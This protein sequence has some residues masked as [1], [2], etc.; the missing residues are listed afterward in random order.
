MLEEKKTDLPEQHKEEQSLISRRKLLASLGMAGVA[1]ASSGIVNAALTTK[2]YADPGDNRTKVKDLMQKALVVSAT[3]AELRTLNGPD[4]NALYFVTDPEQ[5][6]MFSY[7]PSDTASADNGG[8]ILVSSAGARYFR[9]FDGHVNVKWFGAKGNNSHDDT[10]AIQKAIDAKQGTVFLPKGTYLTS[11]P[12]VIGTGDSLVGEG[13]EITIIE[14]TTTTAA[15]LGTRKAG[16]S[17]D[18]YNVDAVII[19]LAP[20]NDYARY[21]H[22]EGLHVRRGTTHSSLP[23]NDSFCFY[24]PRI[25]FL[26]QKNVEYRYAGTGYYTANAWMV[27]LERV[28]SRWVNRGFVC[29]DR[30]AP[31]GGGTGHT[32]TSCWA[33]SCYIGAWKIHAAYSSLIACGA[34]G[35]GSVWAGGSPT[36]AAEY[37]YEINAHG[38]NILSCGTEVARGP[39]FVVKNRSTVNIFGLKTWAYYGNEPASGIYAFNIQDQSEVTVSGGTLTL[40]GAGQIKNKIAKVAGGSK[41]TIVGLNTVPSYLTDSSQ[42]VVDSSSEV[43]ISGSE[44]RS[45]KDNNKKRD[46][47]ATDGSIHITGA[48]D[49][50]LLKFTDPAAQTTSYVWVDVSGALRTKRGAAPS[51]DTDGKLIGSQGTNGGKHSHSGNGSSVQFTIPHGLGAIPGSYQVMPASSDAAGVSFVE[52]DSDNLIVHYASAPSTG[53]N[54]LSWTWS[55]TV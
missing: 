10:Q 28:S 20:D 3:I 36:V 23:K 51:S 18:N 21:V 11:V 15:T 34:D 5:E 33:G 41:L 16:G 38:V 1:I 39:I 9:I 48:W 19:A 44:M 43:F 35:I 50:G 17:T 26:T 7:D 52:A 42:L 27:T 29:G 14:K 8:T 40:E 55:A 2:A 30:S 6:G 46:S 24:A 54:N 49:K 53:S 13:P 31:G 4:V 47:F 32:I 12:L 45:V 22:I 25:Y 37:I